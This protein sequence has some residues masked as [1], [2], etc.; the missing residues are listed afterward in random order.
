MMI[1]DPD[2]SWTADYIVA[3]S[4]E[5]I[6]FWNRAPE[7]DKP[8]V[9]VGVARLGKEHTICDVASTKLN[10]PKFYR[11]NLKSTD[12]IKHPKLDDDDPDQE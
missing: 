10:E 3:K 2:R 12:M 8:N 9:L 5:V 1:A 4:E 11:A 7:G 6:Q